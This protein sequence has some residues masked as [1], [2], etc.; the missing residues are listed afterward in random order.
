MKLVRDRI[1]DVPWSDEENKR[2]LGST[3]PGSPEHH[4]LLVAK[5][6]EEV[7]ELVAAFAAGTQQEVVEEA[8]D[9]YE[10]LL[11]ILS[12]DGKGRPD[13]KLHQA[14][15]EKFNARGGFFRGRTYDDSR[16]ALESEA[17]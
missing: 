14:A 17:G 5:L 12:F 8:A 16:D 9:V 11:G 6:R 1:G 10:V 4:L 7:E 13:V 3:S 2:L 15:V